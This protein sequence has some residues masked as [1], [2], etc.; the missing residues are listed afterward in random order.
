MLTRTPR[1][2]PS[3]CSCSDTPTTRISRGTKDEMSCRSAIISSTPS[4]AQSRTAIRPTSTESTE[5]W[6]LACLFSTRSPQKSTPSS[7]LPPNLKPNLP[8]TSWPQC[9]PPSPCP[10]SHIIQFTLTHPPSN[11]SVQ[12]PSRAGTHFPPSPS[13]Q[14]PKPTHPPT[15]L[16]PI[17]PHLPLRV[18]WLR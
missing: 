13:S 4:L 12:I 9:P 11:L 16:S 17:R 7:L 3:K 6:A 5:S 10:F 2:F 15:P 1:R 8:R 14:K 18:A